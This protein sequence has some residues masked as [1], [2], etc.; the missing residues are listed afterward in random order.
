MEK[1]LEEKI[2]QLVV[3]VAVIKQKLTIAEDVKDHEERIR[4]LEIYKNKTVGALFFGQFL[5]GIV[6][7]IIMKVMQ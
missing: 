6:I 4:A 7:G 1:S 5:I 3:D 2:N